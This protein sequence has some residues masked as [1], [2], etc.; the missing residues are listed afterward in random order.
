MDTK[1]Q[2]MELQAVE[3]GESRSDFLTLSCLVSAPPSPGGKH[4]ARSQRCCPPGWW[5]TSWVILDGP[6]WEYLIKMLV[7]A[8]RWYRLGFQPD[9]ILEEERSSE[10][11]ERVEQRCS[12]AGFVQ[13]NPIYLIYP[14][15]RGA[16]VL[17]TSY[18]DLVQSASNAAPDPDDF[19][20]FLKSCPYERGRK[21]KK[22]EI[23]YG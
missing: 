6:N 7:R 2:Q 12:W 1:N 4:Q 22:V 20:S 9:W 15:Y 5:S 16:V 13:I 19:L 17:I 8:G 10:L 11:R 21:K 18:T 23:S 3:F 14:N